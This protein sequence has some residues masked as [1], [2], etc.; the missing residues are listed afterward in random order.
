MQSKGCRISLL[1]VGSSHNKVCE[2]VNLR[3]YPSYY[4]C[5]GNNSAKSPITTWKSPDSRQEGGYKS[6]QKEGE[7]F[8]GIDKPK[9]KRS[10]LQTRSLRTN[11]VEV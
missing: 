6:G 2:M 11:A 9:L 8:V 7:V 3:E 1:S 5:L 10:S 4:H